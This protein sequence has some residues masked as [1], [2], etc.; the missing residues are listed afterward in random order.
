MDKMHIGVQS[1][2]SK[3]IKKI[4]VKGVQLFYLSHIDEIIEVDI[5]DIHGT[6]TIRPDIFKQM[7]QTIIDGEYDGKVYLGEL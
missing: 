6:M 5:K 3:E 1:K 4:T 2:K 7:I